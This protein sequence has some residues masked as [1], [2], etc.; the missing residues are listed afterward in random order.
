MAKNSIKSERVWNAVRAMFPG[1]E[2]LGIDQRGSMP[3][4]TFE[5]WWTKTE[6]QM[7]TIPPTPKT[8]RQKRGASAT[9]GVG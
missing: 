6:H 1:R 3:K 2:P 4:R 5:V 9:D 7:V 8:P